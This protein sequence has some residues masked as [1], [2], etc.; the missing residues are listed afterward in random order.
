MQSVIDSGS[1]LIAAVLC[2]KKKLHDRLALPSSSDLVFFLQNLLALPPTFV[3][4]ADPRLKFKNSSAPSG[5]RR[6][7]ECDE[8]HRKNSLVLVRDT[9]RVNQPVLMD[10]YVIEIMTTSKNDFVPGVE[11]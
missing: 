8:S 2:S 3:F 9:C 7:R 5:V 11:C 6:G 1:S 4:S 10:P